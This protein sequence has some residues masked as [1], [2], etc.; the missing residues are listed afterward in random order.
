M[1]H[2]LLILLEKLFEHYKRGETLPKGLDKA[3]SIAIHG[4]MILS[5]FIRI[6]VELLVQMVPYQL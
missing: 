6:V 2:T 3:K 4:G 1:K 5:R